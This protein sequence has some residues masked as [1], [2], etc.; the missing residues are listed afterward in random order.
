MG[1][2]LPQFPICWL[3]EL[4]ERL[5][6]NI[7]TPHEKSTFSNTTGSSDWQYIQPCSSVQLDQFFND[8][9]IKASNPIREPDA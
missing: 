5:L 9:H 4:G 1:E 6:K 8:L 3:L 7:S 2:D